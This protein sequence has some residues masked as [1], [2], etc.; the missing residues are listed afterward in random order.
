MYVAHEAHEARKWLHIANKSSFNTSD[1]QIGLPGDS[2]S[3]LASGRA[4]PIEIMPLEI[5][6]FR[7][8]KFQLSKCNAKIHTGFCVR[9]VEEERCERL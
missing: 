1:H 8:D 2:Y 5:I 7:A 9:R 4:C 3:L 6:E